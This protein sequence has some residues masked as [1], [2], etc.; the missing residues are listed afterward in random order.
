MYRKAF[1]SFAA[2]V[3]LGFGIAGM[4][5]VADAKDR[6]FRGDGFRGHGFES[7]ADHRIYEY[8]DGY[9]NYQDC[10]YRRV[11]VKKWNKAHTKRIKIY[12]KRWVCY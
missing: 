7:R 12:K 9:Y 2:T 3:A 6:G 5:S 11:A 1:I 10:R 8:Y 4:T